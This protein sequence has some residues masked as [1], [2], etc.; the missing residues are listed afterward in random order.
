MPFGDAAQVVVEPRDALR[1]HVREV[2][3]REGRRRVAELADVE[4][5]RRVEAGVAVDRLRDVEG[6]VDAALEHV[7]RSLDVV[8]AGER[9]AGCD[10]RL[11]PR[12]I[13]RVNRRVL[14]RRDQRRAR[15]DG[16]REPEHDP[17]LRD[18]LWPERGVEVGPGLDDFC[19]LVVDALCEAVPGLAAAVRDAPGADVGVAHL[20]EGAEE[21]A[22]RDLV[23]GL[24]RPGELD[25]TRRRA[26]AASG[27]GE[28]GVAVRDEDLRDRGHAVLRAAEA[29]Q[30]DDAGPAAG[31]CRS[32][33]L[34]EVVGDRG[35]VLHRPGAASAS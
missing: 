1:H 24:A 31:R 4:V 20:G 8:D 2:G 15:L 19:C 32:V 35:A 12:W 27:V 11:D 16:L 10:E 25:A 18:V 7:R 22:H 29:V 5:L 28:R 23:G 30:D 9:G 17:R 13:G 26:V 3:S 21:G 34:V 14:V 6:V 33:R